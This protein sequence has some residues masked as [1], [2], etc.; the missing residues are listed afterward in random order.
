MNIN[1]TLIGQMITFII[2]VIF[3]M[4]FIWPPLERAMHNRQ[5]RIAEGLS[6]TERAEK[7]LQIAKHNAFTI[8][9][10]AKIQARKIID[11]ANMRAAQIDKQAKENAVNNI[12]RIRQSMN[13][14][15]IVQKQVIKQQL[16]KEVVTIAISIAE[17]LI[18]HDINTKSHDKFLE[19]IFSEL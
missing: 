2:F 1:L 13:S 8:I 4:R 15:V 5:V 10:Q 7:E 16:R 6:F 12:N 11:H 18:Q 19:Q 9:Q 17:K 14:E 3:T